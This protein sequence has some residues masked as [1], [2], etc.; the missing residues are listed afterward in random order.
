MMKN[1]FLCMLLCAIMVISLVGCGDK[2]KKVDGGKTSTDEKLGYTFGEN[3]HSDDPVSYTM[4]WSDHEMYPYQDSWQI[5]DKIKEATN[6]T[7]DFKDYS[8]ARTDY[9]AKKALMINSGQSAYIIPKTYDESAFVD[10]GAVVAVSEWTQYMPNYTAFVEKYKLQPDL[11]TL[12]KADGKYYRLPGLKEAP[13][14]D[15]TLIIRKDIFDAAGVD[16]AAIEKDWK[17]NDLY[18][19]LVKVKEYM[20]SK[21][22]CAAGDYIWSERWPGD[23]GS[24]G[25][26][27]KLMGSSYGVPAG[28]AIGNGMTYSSEKDE[29]YFAS[30]SEDYK[31][32]ITML[33]KFIKGGILDPESFT[34]TDEQACQKFYRGETIIFGSNKAVYTD[35][36]A[37][38]NSTLGEGNYELYITVYPMGNKPYTSENYR[39]ENGV[40]IASK[41]LKD[42]GEEGFIK[43]I[44]FVD[45]LFY[46]EVSYDLRK[47]GVEGE[48]YEVVK[49]ET[50]GK[51]IK[52]LLPQW[53]CGGLAIAQT[54]ED[55]KDMRIE[56]GYAGGVFYYGGTVAQISDAYNPVLQDYFRR[57]N[58]YRELKPLDPTF[59]GTEDENEQMNLWKTPLI[60][61]VNSWTLQF[62]TGQKDIQKDWDAYVSSCKNLMCDELANLY[63]EIYK[64]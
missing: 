55:Q 56:L 16:V 32:F 63:N 33:N 62:A 44:R 1:K 11:D 40:M 9:D 34:Q 28:W 59:A 25:N 45:W 10:G 43:F 20:V 61:N 53:Y 47:W 31:E 39:L 50:T 49:D 60:D 3:F 51:N 18:D 26:L 27:L 4:F 54:S 21:G 13:E 37:N 42:L 22:M 41:A 52:K 17:W 38:L 8:I 19:A 2:S 24:G 6:V 15:Y 58:E 29:W 14:Q 12:K 35:Y 36:I 5:F 64:R 30:I 46:S 57:S 7:L 48:T 23:D